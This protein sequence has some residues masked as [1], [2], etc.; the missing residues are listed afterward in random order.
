M[1]YHPYLL[2]HIQPVLDLQAKHGIVTQA[3]GP[4][5]PIL[6]HPGGPLKPVLSKIAQR[7]GTDEANVLL[8]WTIQNGVVAITTSSNEGRIEKMAQAYKLD[9]LTDA[10]MAEIDKVGRGVHFRSYAVSSGVVTSDVITET[11]ARWLSITGP[12]EQGLP[13]ARPARWQV[14]SQDSEGAEA[15]EVLSKRCSLEVNVWRVQ[16]GSRPPRLSYCDLLSPRLCTSVISKAKSDVN[17][18]QLAST[19]IGLRRQ[20]VNFLTRTI[21]RMTSE[22]LAYF[23][24]HSTSLS[25]NLIRETSHDTC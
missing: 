16:D 19:V 3:Y 21:D 22:A 13:G 25:T 15:S 7:L 1:E 17:E 18:G 2:T 23:K 10:E 4:L 12:Y 24:L 5:S 14:S 9:K 6:R 8:K 20:I 11:R